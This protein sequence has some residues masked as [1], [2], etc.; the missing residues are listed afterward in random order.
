[1]KSPDEL[2]AVL[3]RQWENSALRE[4]RLLGLQSAWP[5][6]L[7]IGRPSPSRLSSDLDSIKQHV[8]AWRQVKV[9]EVV[10]QSIAYRATRSPVD[11]PVQW[12]LHRPTEWIDACANAAMRSEF[13]TM[14]ALVSQT[15]SAFHSLLVRRRSLWRDKPIGEIIQATRLALKL[16]PSCAFGKPLRLLSVESIDTKFFERHAQLIT[17]LLDARFDGQASRIGL[18]TFLGALFESE[19]WLL[20]MDLDGSLLPFKRQRVR[21]SELRATSPPGERLLIVENESCQHQLPAV[22]RTIAIL[23][24]G[25]DLDWT[26]ADWLAAKKVAYWGDIDS[27][28]LQFLARARTSIQHLEA[29]MMTADVFD[30]FP[31]STVRESVPASNDVPLNLTP[32]EQALYTRLLTEPRGRLEQEFL[33]HDLVHAAIAQWI[34]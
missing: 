27:W 26:G 2:K 12:R 24:A 21:S 8:S 31:E 7:S 17:T 22:P 14:S 4:A 11:I 30:R 13:Q 6:E 10:W 3:R 25:F 9:G 18:E 19:H 34:E 5:I 16:E 32:A 33:P 1:M 28:G 29:L 23:G 20:V 15:D